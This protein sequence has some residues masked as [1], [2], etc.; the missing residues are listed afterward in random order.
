MPPK[1]KRERI[2]LTEASLSEAA[3]A[4]LNRVSVTKQRLSGKLEL[5]VRSRCEPADLE[6]ARPLIRALIE[7]FERSRML[8][9]ERFAE[10]AVGALRARGASARAIQYRLAAR[11]LGD[12]SIAHAMAL[13]QKENADSE[14]TAAKAFVRRRRL[15]PFRPDAERAL[16]RWRDIAALGRAGFEKDVARHALEDDG[17]NPSEDEF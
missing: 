14:L 8:D 16:K 5:W 3:L 13:D 7:R 4:I 12:S 6:A 11:G 15:G 9:D 1:R 2:P 10:N 17:A